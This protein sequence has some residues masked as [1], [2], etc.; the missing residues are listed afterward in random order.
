M[1]NAVR[2]QREAEA[3]LARD[4]CNQPEMRRRLMEAVNGME[5]AR[6]GDAGCSI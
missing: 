4:P 6:Y 3:A 1:E 2:A 5:R